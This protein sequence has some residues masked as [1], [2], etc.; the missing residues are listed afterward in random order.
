MTGRMQGQVALVTGAGSGIGLA[1][2]ERFTREG[3]TVAGIDLRG[4]EDFGSASGALFHACDVTDAAAL[5][6]QEQVPDGGLRAKHQH[7]RDECENDRHPAAPVARKSLFQGPKSS[8]HDAVPPDRINI[9]IKIL[10][11][12]I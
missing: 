6:E 2:T 1:C 8:S 11:G 5:Q 4:E 9:S 12:D 7:H 10:P 3:A